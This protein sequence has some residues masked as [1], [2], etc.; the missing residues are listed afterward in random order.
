MPSLNDKGKPTQYTAIRA[1]ITAKKKA[2]EELIEAKKIAEN[3]VKIKDEFL[4]N[5]SHEIRTPMNSI[6][7]FTDL[8]LETDLNSEQDEFLGRIKKSSST[9]FG[10]N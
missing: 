10:I 9:L 2:E 5:M 6:I 8:L 3:S 7:G 4:R 1:D